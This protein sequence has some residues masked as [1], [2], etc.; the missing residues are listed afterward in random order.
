MM[1]WVKLSEKSEL[2]KLLIQTESGTRLDSTTSALGVEINFDWDGKL[3]IVPPVIPDTSLS[4]LK[5][6]VNS[7]ANG[8]DGINLPVGST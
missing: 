8:S 2:C 1:H 3:G 5:F 4:I 6:A 7:K